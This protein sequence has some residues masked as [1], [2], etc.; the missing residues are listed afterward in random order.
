[1]EP[2]GQYI[3]KNLDLWNLKYS[4]NIQTYRIYIVTVQQCL[5]VNHIV[6]ECHVSTQ[7]PL[8]IVIYSFFSSFENKP[9]GS[10]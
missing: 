10:K 9:W 4:G 2:R 8:E 7:I 6:A 5:D 1:M 3:G